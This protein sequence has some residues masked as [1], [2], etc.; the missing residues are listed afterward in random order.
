MRN[1]KIQDFG[2]KLH[3]ARKDLWK[4]TPSLRD[5]SALTDDELIRV[6]VKSRIW[7]A[8]EF[9]QLP[10]LGVDPECHFRLSG[11]RRAIHPQPVRLPEWTV[12]EMCLLYFETLVFVKEWAA[13]LRSYQDFEDNAESLISGYFLVPSKNEDGQDEEAKPKESDLWLCPLQ[14]KFLDWEGQ[15]EVVLGEKFVWRLKRRRV[16]FFGR[17]RRPPR[18]IEEIMAS[19]TGEYHFDV[20]TFF[21]AARI[22][23]FGESKVKEGCSGPAE[24]RLLEVASLGLRSL[25]R[26]EHTALRQ[27]LHFHIRRR[28]SK[29]RWEPL[30]PVRR[31]LQERFD[32]E[33]PA[34]E[35]AR[36]LLVRGGEFGNWVPGSERS[37]KLRLL[38]EAFHDLA[39]ILG[40]SMDEVSL[41]GKLGL[42]VGSRGRGGRNPAIAHFEPWSNVINL[43]RQKSD[44]SLCHEWAHALDLVLGRIHT[45]SQ[46]RT[47]RFVRYPYFSYEVFTKVQATIRDRST[48][49][50]GLQGKGLFHGSPLPQEVI[51]PIVEF[52][53]EFYAHFLLLPEAEAIEHEECLRHSRYV[54][55]IE[56]LLR[57]LLVIP[58]ASGRIKQFPPANE[59]AL[60]QISKACRT[61]SE[62]CADGHESVETLSAA[63]K[64]VVG[65]PLGTHFRQRLLISMELIQQIRWQTKSLREGTGDWRVPSQWLRSLRRETPYW[66]RPEELFARAVEA[67]V[68]DRMANRK[69]SNSFLL[70]PQCGDPM[71]SGYYPGGIERSRFN[72]LL[73]NFFHALQ[74]HGV[75][76]NLVSD[77]E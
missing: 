67:F 75:L 74:K 33:L 69:A 13:T 76:A 11:L 27:R 29:L 35:I 72:L 34:E 32:P 2:E 60:E 36:S 56:R 30:E 1:A 48:W 61:I 14:G 5:L 51:Q 26:A 55:E 41:G 52:A 4:A 19:L 57:E 64:S 45:A 37:K 65:Q 3:G 39:E 25:S 28:A 10:L 8:K 46:P 62:A 58:F 49:K 7:T 18:P 50:D 22:L 9:T 68:L 42:A 44:G 77:K 15:M 24:F 17:S 53:H 43:T 63:V 21:F 31:G 38:A 59:A 12:R 71:W 6:A 70:S 40:L 16:V 73:T 47:G 23:Y 54:E 66:R 20:D